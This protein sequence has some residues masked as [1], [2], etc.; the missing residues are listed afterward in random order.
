MELKEKISFLE[1]T[2]KQESNFKVGDRY[3]IL[4]NES[5]SLLD[6]TKQ[7]IKKD[8]NYNKI[9]NYK[10]SIKKNGEELLKSIF[11]NPESY[12]L[13]DYVVKE[14]SKGEDLCH[15]LENTKRHLKYGLENQIMN[16]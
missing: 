12:E 1:K 16:H 4:K 15:L 7:L 9:R 3:K 14:Y 5:E 11:Y 2:I 13:I 10:K 6:L 8:S